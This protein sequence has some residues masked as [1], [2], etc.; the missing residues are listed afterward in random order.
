MIGFWAKR[1]YLA[2]EMKF[3]SLIVAAAAFLF[4]GACERHTWDDED[5]NKDGKIDQNEKG[6]SRLYQKEDHGSE[7]QGGHPEEG[8]K[9]HVEDAG[10]EAE[11]KH[12]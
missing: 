2:R 1:G 8:E 4:V 9:G 12:D 7:P 11:K 6:T 10:N 3:L 5:A